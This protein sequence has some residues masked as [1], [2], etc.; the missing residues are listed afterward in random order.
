MHCKGDCNGAWQLWGWVAES[1]ETLACLSA[2]EVQALENF[3][4]LPPA[5][6]TS[7]TIRV[8]IMMMMRRIV[9]S[10]LF[11]P[12]GTV[13]KGDT[14]DNKKVGD[15]MLWYIILVISYWWYCIGDFIL[16][17]FND[18]DDGAEMDMFATFCQLWRW[19]CIFHQNPI[20]DD[21]FPTTSCSIDIR[22]SWG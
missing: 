22:K 4:K 5:K 11:F 2:V 21:R 3:S 1:F 14:P 9:I 19:K 20:N 7:M 6:S 18:R 12:P 8:S 17:I 10:L 13:A 16:V 15:I